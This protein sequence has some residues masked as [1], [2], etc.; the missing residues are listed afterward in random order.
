[1]KR[2]KAGDIG[3][4]FNL[5]EWKSAFEKQALLNDYATEASVWRAVKH[6]R[7]HLDEI[8]KLLEA[9]DEKG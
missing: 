2:T 1:M 4:Y 3:Y 8:E 7:R 6:C 5:I 9:D